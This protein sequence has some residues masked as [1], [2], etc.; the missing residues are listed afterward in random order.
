MAQEFLN[1]YVKLFFLLTPFFLISTFLAMA[2]NMTDKERIST[3]TR[4]TIAILIASITL[5][6]LGQYIFQVMGITIDA[7]RIGA[8]TFLFLSAVTLV[9]GNVFY[10]AGEME[11]DIAVVPLALPVAVGPG[12]TGALIVMSMEKTVS[13]PVTC[14][15]IL[16]AVL[17]VGLMLH[18]AARGEK[19]LRPRVMSVLTRLMGLVVASMAAELIF[20]GIRNIFNS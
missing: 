6:I 17:T 18:I 11:E 14:A 1:T 3:A 9:R 16:A 10:Q 8:G 5:Y 4:T 13:V 7:F 2:K 15:S 19:F 20:T 12:T